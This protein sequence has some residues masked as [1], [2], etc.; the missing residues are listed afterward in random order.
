MSSISQ[1]QQRQ[2]WKEIKQDYF[3]ASLLLIHLTSFSIKHI[4]HSFCCVDLDYTFASRSP[5]RLSDLLSE[6]L[7]LCMCLWQ[8][9]SVSHPQTLERR[10]LGIINGLMLDLMKVNTREKTTLSLIPAV[11]IYF[12][13][14]TEF[15]VL[16]LC[17]FPPFA[18]SEPAVL[19]PDRTLS[20]RTVSEPPRLSGFEGFRATSS[21][22]AHPTS[23]FEKKTVPWRQHYP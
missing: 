4:H 22:L 9:P 13:I 5:E 17:D 15:T 6:M 8:F 10:Y 14:K 7:L 2:D 16:L 19:E 18:V 3:S 1:I 20:N 23:L 12:K 21:T 11:M